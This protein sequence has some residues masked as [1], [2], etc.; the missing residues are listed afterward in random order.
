MMCTMWISP[1]T[2]FFLLYHFD[3]NEYFV[4][5]F[6]QLM[7]ITNFKRKDNDDEKKNYNLDFISFI[8]CIS[9]IL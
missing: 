3:R 9:G 8:G 7:F 2:A 1:L 6:L 5:C 4:F